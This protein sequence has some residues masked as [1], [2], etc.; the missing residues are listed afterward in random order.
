LKIIFVKFTWLIALSSHLLTKHT[1][2]VCKSCHRSEEGCP[3]GQPTDGKVLLNQLTEQAAR[4][5]LA[6]LLEIKP[7]GCLW[8]C[9]R[10]CVVAL[11]SPNKPAYLLLDLPPDGDHA[12]ALLQMMQLYIKSRKGRLNWDKMPKQLEACL[13]AQIP[14]LPPA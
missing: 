7:V 12:D 1:L 9:Q 11:A 6:E 10:G 2:F 3:K 5:K 13:F 14:A 4:F 8:A